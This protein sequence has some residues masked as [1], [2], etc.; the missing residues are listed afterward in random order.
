MDI[1]LRFHSAIT[2]TVILM[3]GI[4]LTSPCLADAKLCGDCIR[5][6]MALH[7]PACAP[8][9]RCMAQCLW[10]GGSRS[11]CVKQCDG[12]G[13]WARLWSCKRCMWSCKCSCTS[14]SS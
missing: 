12:G 11:R 1:S 10:G 14:S 4:C 8:P 9:L 3:T 2:A 7:C 5:D 6:R 13:A